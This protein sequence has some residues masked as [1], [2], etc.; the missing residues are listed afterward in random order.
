MEPYSKESRY[1]TTS[2]HITMKM[3]IRRKKNKKEMSR[4]KRRNMQKTVL[5]ILI[6]T[7]YIF[8]I[9]QLYFCFIVS[10]VDN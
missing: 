7:K 4:D 1:L 6:E 2:G 10:N 8:R 3:K 9:S 5:T